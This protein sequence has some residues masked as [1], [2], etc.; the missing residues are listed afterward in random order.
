MNVW[1]MSV[2]GIFVLGA[3]WAWFVITGVLL[4]KWD[5]REHRLPNN[6]VVAALMGGLLGFIS[7]ALIEADWVS[8]GR[9][10]IGA[11]LCVVI[12]LIAHV[13][14]GMGMGDVK[15]SAVMGL[16]LG[17]L[18]W[19]SI[20]GGLL[21]A[22]GLASLLAVTGFILKRQRRSIPFGPFMAMGV[23]ISGAISL[24]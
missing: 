24:T 12:F 20:Y 16:Y 7:F 23:V 14:G 8:I 18:G 11:I 17:W 4:A 5:F 19:G 2:W 22:F 6:L 21:I 3:T 10:L 15:Y 1:G 13:C 9:G